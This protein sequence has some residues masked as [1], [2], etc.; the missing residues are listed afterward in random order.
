MALLILMPGRD[1]S[2]L[3]SRLRSIQPN[4]DVRVW[5]EDGEKS[6]ID[7]AVTW[8]HPPGELK[9][10][11][12]LKAISSYGAGVDH[13]ISDPYLPKNIPIARIIDEKLIH[14]V[15]EYVIAVV[16]SHR[17][18]L[19]A[20]WENQKVKKWSP[21]QMN[22][23]NTIGILGLGQIGGHIA[24]SFIQLGFHVCGWDQ[25]PKQIQGVQLFQ[26]AEQLDQLLSI[27]DYLI[28]SLPL[29]PETR[30]ILN[31][32]TFGKLKKNAYVINVG[33]G[34]HLVEEDLIKAI[35]KDRVSGACLD[36]FRSE[37]L[38]TDHPFWSHPKITVTPHIAGITDPNAVASQIFENYQRIT[39]G[40]EPIHTIDIQ[41]GF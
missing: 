31:E 34:E 28:C 32:K 5:P 13:I 4:I 20:Y 23:A 15:K 39:K 7:F 36:V 37:P 10:Y 26:G 19:A 11:P 25:K 35:E 6:E 22:Q 29:T 24:E 3:V 12:N 41:L 1:S 27:V 30:N 16:L 18:H 9:N 33:R 38:Q 21:L 17:R 8:K 2:E 40:K 14:D